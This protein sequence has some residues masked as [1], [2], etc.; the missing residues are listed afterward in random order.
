LASFAVVAALQV[1]A[2]ASTRKMRQVVEEMNIIAVL[3]EDIMREEQ[4][5]CKLI[6]IEIMREVKP[7]RF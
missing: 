5:C 1:A 2:A 3:G 7:S 6:A 4:R